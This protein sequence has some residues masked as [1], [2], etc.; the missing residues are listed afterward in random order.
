MDEISVQLRNG[1]EVRV[2]NIRSVV[3]L[4]R[5]EVTRINST[6]NVRAINATLMLALEA[7]G[8]YWIRAFLPKRFDPRYASDNLGYSAKPS[9][10]AFKR[11]AA[12]SGRPTM[13]E[14]KDGTEFGDLVTVQAPQ[15]TP[16][17]FSGRSRSQVLGGTAKPNAIVKASGDCKLFVNFSWGAIGFTKQAQSFT[18]V[19]AFEHARVTDVVLGTFEREIKGMLQSGLIGPGFTKN[20]M[21][22]FGAAGERSFP[23]VVERKS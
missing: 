1:R 15:P 7:G 23:G 9:Y 11:N 12:Q 14:G 13:F 3:A 21:R 8:W 19:P 16:F 2:K 6:M 5:A 18:F 20:K 17:V 10:E 22:E 4:M